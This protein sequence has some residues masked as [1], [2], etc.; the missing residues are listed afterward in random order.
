MKLA[1]ARSDSITVRSVL[2]PALADEYQDAIS[3]AFPGFQILGR[4]E[5]KFPSDLA[6]PLGPQSNTVQKL[7]GIACY[8]ARSGTLHDCGSSSWNLRSS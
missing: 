3:N 8:D 7:T 2:S 1:Y 6:T 4:S 5:I